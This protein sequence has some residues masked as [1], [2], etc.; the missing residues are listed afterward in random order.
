MIIWKITENNILSNI[1]FLINN[2]NIVISY[3]IQVN[4]IIFL[5]VKLIFHC[6]KQGL[7][8]LPI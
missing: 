7:T 3:N 6:R 8:L 2:L 4:L 5:P 1:I